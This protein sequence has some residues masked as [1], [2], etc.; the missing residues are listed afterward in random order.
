[1]TNDTQ[2]RRGAPKKDPAHIRSER[3]NIVLT[4]TTLENLRALSGLKNESINN[5][6]HDLIDEEADRN[7]DKIKEYREFM[8]RMRD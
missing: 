5:I 4:P 6:V 8:E 2:G 1:M 3:V 7:A